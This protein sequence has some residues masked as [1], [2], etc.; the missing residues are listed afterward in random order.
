M[1]HTQDLVGVVLLIV[2]VG[3]QLR[4]AC[5]PL[6]VHVEGGSTDAGNRLAAVYRTQTHTRAEDK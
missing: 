2:N 6:L 3:P 1:T 4:T 5:L